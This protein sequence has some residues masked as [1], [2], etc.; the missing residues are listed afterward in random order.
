MLA[1]LLVAH[2]PPVTVTA[3]TLPIDSP[4]YA[5]VLEATPPSTSS[6]P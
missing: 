3:P 2:V 6:T 1:M 5:L 4:I